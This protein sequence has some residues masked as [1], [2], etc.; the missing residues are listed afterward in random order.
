MA[1]GF[2]CQTEA[3]DFAPRVPE[4]V[5]VGKWPKHSYMQDRLMWGET[6]SKEKRW[7]AFNN[8][9]NMRR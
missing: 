7:M 6:R 3:S 2:K 9:L 1:E 5:L 4:I 8:N